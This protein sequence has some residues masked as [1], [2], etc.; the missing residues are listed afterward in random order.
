MNSFLYLFPKEES[1]LLNEKSFY[2]L[3]YYKRKRLE[4]KKKLKSARLS[5]VHR[6]RSF[7]QQKKHKTNE[8]L[9]KN[10]FLDQL[11]ESLSLFLDKKFNIFLTLKNLNRG[12]SVI[13]TE[14]ERSFL[15]KKILLLKRY[16]RD[17][18][19]KE[20]LNI[21]LIVIK[22]K[23]SSRLFAQFIA[24]QLSFLKRHNY[25]LVFLKRI[26]NIFIFIKTSKVKGIKIRISG[27]F[28]GAPRAKSR[29]ITVGNVPVQ[30]I[31]KNIDYYET[32]SYTRNG[33]FGVKLWINY[34]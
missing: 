17:K 29:V 28:N 24:Q 6:Y 30:T 18:F 9:Q 11:L 2:K 16:N 15:K 34:E 19:F 8:I 10:R 3:S 32:A 4:Q 13:L 33:T 26:L 21:M 7:L 1:L 25:F 23:S 31:A 5:V 12:L 27:R 20:S 14:D 22:I